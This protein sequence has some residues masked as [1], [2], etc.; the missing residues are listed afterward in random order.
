M[1]SQLENETRRKPRKIPV[2]QAATQEK[3]QWFPAIQDTQT[4]PRNNQLSKQTVQIQ[5][6]FDVQSEWKDINPACISRT[7]VCFPVRLEWLDPLKATFHEGVKLRAYLLLS[8]SPV[9]LISY[10][11]KYTTL[12]N[13]AGQRE[14][15]V[16][17]SCLETAFR[18][19]A[20]N[21]SIHRRDGM[22][23]Q[24][25]NSPWLRVHTVRCGIS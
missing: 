25:L 24:D 1:I 13:N 6:N 17:E 18:C 12:V 10:S 11:R 9:R 5:I 14:A 19:T 8:Y 23:E 20:I 15:K 4:N 7:C 16:G 2:V 3:F 21:Q 22:P